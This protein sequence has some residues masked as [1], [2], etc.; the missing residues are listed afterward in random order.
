MAD[1]YLKTEAIAELDTQSM[2]PQTGPVAIAP[3][4]I[5]KDEQ[6]VGIRIVV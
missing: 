4:A 6:A 3:T 2:F 5:G 1:L